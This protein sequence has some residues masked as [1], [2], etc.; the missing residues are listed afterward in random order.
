M[1]LDKVE[2]MEY[3][4]FREL[5]GPLWENRTGATEAPVL[6]LFER[7]GT[8]FQ[9][10]TGAR[11]P[12]RMNPDAWNMDQ[13]GLDRPGNAAIQLDLQ[14]NYHTNLAQYPAWHAYLKAHQPPALVVWGTG[15]PLFGVAGVERLRHDLRDCEVHLLDTGH[16]ALEE[17]VDV[18]AERIRA[19][20][21][22]RLGAA[23]RG[24]R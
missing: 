6:E 1:S 3:T 24:D 5:L 22:A 15:D 7:E 10:Q 21:R 14:A 8:I 9:Y 17:E 13:W 16:F 20:L 2:Y 19:F 23:R 18:I 11:A 12:E 4:L